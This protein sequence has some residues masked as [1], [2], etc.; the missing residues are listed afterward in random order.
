M[1]PGGDP[2]DVWRRLYEVEGPGT[3][4]I[5]LYELV[6]APR[7]LEPH[8]LPVAERLEL[9]RAAMAVVWPG[10][11]IVPGSERTGDT[12]EIVDYDPEWP[13]AFARWHAAIGR[14]LGHR[15][16][17]VDHIGSTSVPGLPAKAIVDILICVSDLSDEPSYVP[18]L[19]AIGLQLRSRDDLHRYFRPFRDR[20]RDVHAHVCE[21]GSGWQI[22]HLLFRD[23]LRA[24]PDAHDAY[25]AVKRDAAQRWGDDG[26]AYTDAKSALIQDTLRAARAWSASSKGG[27]G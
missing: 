27:G 13:N 23:F 14:S 16:M 17:R 22:D 6:A 18:G 11:A 20:P 4:V 15:A 19:E 2:M 10:N 8:E 7:G 21:L 5:D 24:H 26:I 12:I 9:A 1:D 25:A 3:T